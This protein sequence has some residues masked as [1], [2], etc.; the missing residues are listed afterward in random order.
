MERTGFNSWP[1]ACALEWDL[2]FWSVGGNFKGSSDLATSIPF[3][4]ARNRLSIPML[5][6]SQ[7]IPFAINAFRP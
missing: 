6:Q 3:C 7:G 5:D 1:R 2:A 4:L